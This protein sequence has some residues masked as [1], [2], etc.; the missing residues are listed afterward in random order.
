MPHTKAL[1][2]FQLISGKRYG[3]KSHRLTELVPP[4]SGVFQGIVRQIPVVTDRPGTNTTGFQVPTS[5]S[6][7]KA[8]TAATNTVNAK[9]LRMGQR[10]TVTYKNPILKPTNATFLYYNYVMKFTDVEIGPG[11]Y[12]PD[13]RLIDSYT[14]T[15]YELPK[16][17]KHG[18]YK[19]SSNSSD[20][21]SSIMVMNTN[22]GSKPPSTYVK[23]NNVSKP[24]PAKRPKTNTRKH[25]NK[26]R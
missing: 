14:T 15:V 26:R 25:K 13:T 4:L 1:N 10:Y 24:P 23:N 21:S 12:I 5:S 8:N 16:E 9:N 7:S 6:F 22:M 11:V 20:S 19:V 2:P 17:A 18:L 3:L